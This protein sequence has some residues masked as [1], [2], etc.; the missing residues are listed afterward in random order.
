MSERD[1][2]PRGDQ[3]EPEPRLRVGFWIVLVAAIAV[4]AGL[5]GRSLAPDASPT[6]A[7]AAP[8]R[9]IV[10]FVRQPS[11]P[12]LAE[13]IDRLCPGIAIVGTATPAFAVSADGWLMA[14]GP[15]ATTSNLQAVFGDGR[16]TT[17]DEVR[18]DPVSGLV[19]AHTGAPGLAPLSFADQNFARVGDFGFSLATANGTGCS[20][21]SSMIGSDF[22]V[23]ALA[24]GIYLRLQA[25]APG[26]A[27]GSAFFGSDGTVLAV[28]T[29]AGNNALLPAPLASAI[30]DELI[31]NNLSPIAS[32]GFRAVDFTPELA[33]R[34]GDLRA[35]GAGVALVQAKSS[36]E[37]AGLRAGDVVIAVDQSPV[38][39]ASELSRA[40]DAV[41]DSAVLTV[42]RGNQQL[43]VEVSRS[44]RSPAA[45]PS[46]ANPS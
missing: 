31:R 27:P 21:Q 23:D 18:A 30:A 1:S 42:A 33:S 6:Q 43:N 11:F 20:A 9:P 14:S 10:Q 22:L 39:S 46:A 5:I 3:T 44:I 45:R 7:P 32:F 4:V 28:A 40:L 16:K 19:V 36:A 35:R 17:V 41:T 37:K 24:Q 34:L 29:S 38:S 8:A 13:T 2:V 26:L 25:G 12:S 15:L